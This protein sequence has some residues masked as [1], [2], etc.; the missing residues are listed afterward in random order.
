MAEPIYMQIGEGSRS[1]DL[2]DLVTAMGN[3]LGLLREVDSTVSGAKIGNLSWKVTT[4]QNEPAP[5][6]G[7]TPN[8]RLRK[9]VIN[10]TSHLVEREIITNVRTL[11]E[12]GERNKFLSDAALTKIENIAKTTERIGDS[13]IYSATKD[14]MKLTT[15]VSVATLKQLKELT[16]VKSTSFGTITGTLDTI[17]VRRGLEFKI[18][19][20]V[21]ARPVSCHL[22]PKQIHEAMSLLGKRVIVTGV[23]RADR[24]GRPISMGV[25]VFLPFPKP[26]VYPTIEEMRGLVPNFTGTLSLKE[27]FE[28]FD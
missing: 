19:D 10:D 1:L 25:K 12:R 18:L 27:F 20:D 4:L 3:F 23:L 24:Y 5:L 22:N 15:S 6:I 28:D 2:P 21:S 8:V 7:V 17:S 11:S 14:S 26:T 9:R 13:T 16:S